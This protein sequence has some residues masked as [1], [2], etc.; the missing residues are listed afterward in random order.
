MGKITLDLY[1]SSDEWLKLYRGSSRI[2][3]A[4]SREGKKVQFPANIVQKY[5]T[6]EGISG[7][8]V[9]YF[10]EQGKFQSIIKL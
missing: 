9:I 4:V 1:I 7:S 5:L 2:V 6:H 10:N 3:R 8:F